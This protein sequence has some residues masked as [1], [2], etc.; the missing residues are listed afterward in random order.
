MLLKHI[1]IFPCIAG[2]ILCCTSPVIAQ[3]DE[4]NF[5]SYTVKDG[6]SD[7]NILCIQ[8]DE[9]GY[10]WIGTDEGLNRF[11]GNSFKKFYRGVPPLN[12]LSTSVW[13]LIRFGNNQI[14]ILNQGGFQ[15]LDTKKY[16]TRNY[17]IPD[18]TPISTYLNAAW[19]A[20]ELPDRSYAVTTATGFYHFNNSGKVILRHDAYRAEDI[21]RKRILYGRNFYKISDKKYL[22]YVNE[23]SIAMYDDEKKIFRELPDHDSEWELLLNS[24]FKQN[25]YWSVK[26]QLNKYEF[27]FVRGGMNQITYYNADLKK[28]VISPLPFHMADSLNWESKIV[29]LNDSVLAIN[30]STNGFYLLKIDHHT[31]IISTDGTK[32]L[33][34]YKIICL[35]TDK[36]NRLW[37]GTREGLLKQELRPPFI[38]AWHYQPSGGEKYT[39][40]FSAVYRYKDKLYAGRFSSS[41]GLAIINPSTMKLI[42]EIDFFSNKSSWNEI[43]S[44]EMYYKDT[45]WIG[46]NGGLLWFDTKTEHYGKVLD[47]KK[48][49]WT[50]GFYPV[51]AAARPDGYAWMCGLLGGKVIRYHIPSRTFTLFTSQTIPALPFD[52]VKNVV[53][54]SYGDV[55]ISGHSLARWNNQQNKFDT[56]ITVYGG[57]NKFNDDIVTIR[58]DD[59]G[60]LWI[61]NFYNGL[62]EYRI[63]EKRFVAY[64]IKDGLPSDVLQSMSP[65]IDNKLWVAANNQIGLFD[66]RTK[67]FTIYNYRDGLPEHKPTGRKIYYDQ[68]SRLLY[69]CSNEYLARFPFTPEKERDHSSHL[70]IQEITVDN[71]KSYYDAEKSLRINNNENNLTVN[72]SVIDYEKGNYQFAWKLNNAVS[73]NVVGNQRSVSLSNLPPGK[74]TL[75]LKASGKPGTEKITDL[76]FTIRPPYWKTWWFAGL[77]VFLISG[78]VYLIYRYRIRYIRQKADVDKMLSQTEMKALQAQMNPHFIFNSLNSIR[79]MILNNENKD[80]SHYLSKFAHLIRITLDQSTQAMVSLRNTIDYLQRY[81]EMEKIRNALFNWDVNT[82]DSLDP[83]ETLVPPMLI[84]PFIENALWHGVSAINKKIHVRIDFRKEKDALVCTIDDNGVGIRQSLKNKPVTNSRHRPH[85]IDNIKNRVN[86]LNKKYNLHARIT[87][88]DKKDIPGNTDTGTIVTLQLPLELK[89][90]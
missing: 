67:Q 41:N 66:I 60:S 40:G 27:V 6:L 54:D 7:N 55:W 44:M 72:Y 68:E 87:I 53:Y 43:R 49:D 24:P 14:G 48:Y 77:A 65:V 76:S 4:N 58:A 18:S 13:K 17:F 90:P 35:F 19:D 16:T 84:Q 74:Y 57:P 85:G 37:A 28:T 42:K 30:S 88:E 2:I 59:N 12:L 15:L 46:S 1:H 47:E 20:I 36:D 29:P 79:E 69:L 75:H 11:D 78:A 71:K 56:L 22:V 70:M 82:N 26:Q 32:Y 64:S 86:L 38:N 25:N 39:G 62:L 89:E 63:K 3:Y 5:T 10:L 33:R 8:Q 50:Q 52:K 81:M 45:L 31:G 80:A 73:W 34:N 9:Q 61:H 51:L 23:A 21:G 83:D